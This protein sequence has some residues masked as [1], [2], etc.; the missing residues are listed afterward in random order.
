MLDC[1]LIYDVQFFYPLRLGGVPYGTE[2]SREI[3][4]AIARIFALSAKITTQNI[5]FW[6]AREN[7]STQNILTLS[8]TKIRTLR[9]LVT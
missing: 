2:F 7:K 9:N 8:S 5:I 6:S 3:N 4:F 1:Y